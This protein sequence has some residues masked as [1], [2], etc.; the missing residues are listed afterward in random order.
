VRFVLASASPARLAVLRA[1]GV[2]PDVVV[3]G[4]DEEAVTAALSDPT[5]AELVTALARAKAEDVAGRVSSGDTADPTAAADTPATTDTVVVGCDSMLFIG[6]ELVG[7]PGTVDAARARWRNMAGG[8]GELLTGHAVVRLRNGDVVARAEGTRA[9]TVRFSTP[10]AE[11]L[12]AYLATG[13]PLAVAGAFTL[14]GLGGW[15]VEGVDG[16]PSSVIGIS[17]PLTRR[18]L[19]E[20]GVSVPHLWSES[21]PR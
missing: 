21:A 2:D 6:G 19:A 15:F 18:L 16:D 1:A 14:D 4:V 5:P 9:T 7:K 12:D 13:E 10:S 20:V 3:S 11:E 17:L 8:T